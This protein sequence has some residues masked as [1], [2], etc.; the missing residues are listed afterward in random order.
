MIRKRREASWELVTFGFLITVI[1][2]LGM[3][4]RILLQKLLRPSISRRRARSSDDISSQK[5]C[6]P[7]AVR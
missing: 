5:V 3:L 4:F 2:L 6:K 7:D 1:I